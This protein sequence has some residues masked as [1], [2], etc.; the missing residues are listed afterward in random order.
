MFS[1]QKAVDMRRIGAEE[2]RRSAKAGPQQS[3]LGSNPTK[4]MSTVAYEEN[5]LL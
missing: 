4:A 5:P 2:K 3:D 1:S